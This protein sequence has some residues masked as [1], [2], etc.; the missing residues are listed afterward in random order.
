MEELIEK[1]GNIDWNNVSD[2]KSG[3]RFDFSV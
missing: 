1:I 3:D 2:S